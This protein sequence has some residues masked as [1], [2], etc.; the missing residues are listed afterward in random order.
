MKNFTDEELNKLPKWAR[1][2]VEVLMK[3]ME[4]LERKLDTFDGKGETRFF[5]HDG[6]KERPIAASGLRI[7]L[8]TAIDKRKHVDL[9]VDRETGRL[10]VYAARTLVV[11]S[12]AANACHLDS[13][14]D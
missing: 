13:I 14:D 1:S 3:D 2:K 7:Y 5:V 4:S 10:Q 6:L 8:G 12:R 11:Y 9:H